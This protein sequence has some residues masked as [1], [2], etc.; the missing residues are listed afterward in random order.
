MLNKS[1]MVALDQHQIPWDHIIRQ[2]AV[3]TSNIVT[4]NTERQPTSHK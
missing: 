2:F 1:G 4:V 3:A